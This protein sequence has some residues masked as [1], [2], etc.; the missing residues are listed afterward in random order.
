MCVYLVNVYMRI[1][2]KICVR[3]RGRNVKSLHTRETNIVICLCVWLG[4]INMVPEMSV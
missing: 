2:D 1:S 3:V 4:F